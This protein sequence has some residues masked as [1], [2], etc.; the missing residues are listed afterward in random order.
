MREYL[1]NLLGYV[2]YGLECMV[3]IVCAL[4]CILLRKGGER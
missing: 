2:Q 4:R 1:I 3:D